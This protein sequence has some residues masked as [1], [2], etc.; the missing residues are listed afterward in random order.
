MP[1]LFRSDAFKVTA[2][3]VAVILLGA[4][5]APQLHAA[6][7][8]AL[9]RGVFDSG[10]LASVKDSVERAKITRF[11]N[12]AVMI[13]ALLL[14]WPFIKW[15]GLKRGGNWLLLRKN[16]LRFGHF[17]LG[18]GIAAGTLLLLGA[19]YVGIGWY[20]MND[21]A[22]PLYRMILSSIGPAL[23][24]AFLEEFLFRGVLLALILR[25][26]RPFP[27]LLFLSS[28]FA[29]V[30]FL[31]PPEHLDLPPIQWDTG[32]WLL[33]KIFGQLGNVD[34]L[35]A[36]LVLLFC[37]GW[38]LGWARLKTASLWLPI[39]LHSGWVFGVKLFS[40]ATRKV[41]AIDDMLPFAGP[42]LRV[43]FN[44]VIV[45]C[46]CGVILWVLLRKRYPQSAFAPF[47]ESN[48]MADKKPAS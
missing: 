35:L 24:V 41:A 34:F 8:W 30:H 13:S 25:T 22:K 17:G 27:A 16:P 3:F 19:V 39:G 5:L 21:E 40:A 12:R 33:T 6:A 20:R 44:S 48:P 46:L 37:V 47:S 29:V 36:E 31:K 2:Y 28:F 32:F 4:L 15:I 23:S 11:F 14:A 9:D 7:Q 43:G 10:P 26:L 18:F 42:H 38:V 1:P 45:V